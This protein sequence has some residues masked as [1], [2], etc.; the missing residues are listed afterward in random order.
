[1]GPGTTSWSPRSILGADPTSIPG[2][3]DVR[4]EGQ[5]PGKGVVPHSKPQAAGDHG[6]APPVSIA[7]K[8][9][10]PPRA[11]LRIRDA[12]NATPAPFACIAL[13]ENG[14]PNGAANTR[15]L[16]TVNAR[17]PLDERKRGRCDSQRDGQSIRIG[18]GTFRKEFRA[19][20]G[21]YPME[22]LVRSRLHKAKEQLGKGFPITEVAHELGFSS[23]QYF[24]TVFRKYEATSPSDFLDVSTGK[25]HRWKYR[26]AARSPCAMFE[27]LN[28]I[29]NAENCAGCSLKSRRF[30]SPAIQLEQT[31][32]QTMPRLYRQ[33]AVLCAV[34]WAAIPVSAQ[35]SAIS[36]SVSTITRVQTPVSIS[37]PCAEL[38]FDS[39]PPNQL[40][41]S[42]NSDGSAVSVLQSGKAGPWAE[43]F[44]QVD[45]A[46]SYRVKPGF[47]KG[48]RKGI[49]QLI[50]NGDP[51]GDPI[52]SYSAGS[53]SP[54]EAVPG[55]VTF[56]KAG[57]Y[58]FRF[59]VTGKNQSS[60]GFSLSLQNML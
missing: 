22:Y 45:Q 9:T 35:L 18:R 19:M 49:F 41:R 15:A 31:P 57:I 48:P 44:I 51:V 12:R 55:N 8:R 59:L 33:F 37:S 42:E 21:L 27:R 28:R 25:V 60:S 20:M 10:C 46:G 43:F 14:S 7:F 56:Q 52:D 4:Y 24:A 5:S 29:P 54:A 58:S 16:C 39:F 47:L 32:M 34:S 11:L 30:A 6:P 1:M 40:L 13:L 17:H 38:P 26:Q 23:S 36:G 50:V 3:G 53:E 2:S